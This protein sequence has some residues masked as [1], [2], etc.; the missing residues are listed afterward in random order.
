MLRT[1]LSTMT[2]LTVA[3]GLLSACGRS[4]QYQPS[5]T[6]PGASA[7]AARAS[8]ER[9]PSKQEAVK[10]RGCLKNEGF[11]A[12]HIR[13]QIRNG[14]TG[15]MRYGYPVTQGEYASAVHRCVARSSGPMTAG[16][17]R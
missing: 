16:R 7:A 4:G 6:V 1:Y 5:A 14:D 17:R 12:S 11:R 8:L 13:G 15:L 3:A 9:M 2:A 10:A